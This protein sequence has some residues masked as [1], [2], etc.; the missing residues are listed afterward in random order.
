M[1][2]DR[3]SCSESP[4]P[5]IGPLLSHRATAT[6]PA[7]SQNRS[8]TAWASAG[9]GTTSAS[10]KAAGTAGRAYSLRTSWCSCDSATRGFGHLA[11]RRF[12]ESTTQ[13]FCHQATRGGIHPAI[14]RGSVSNHRAT[15]WLGDWATRG[16]S[17]R[18][19]WRPS[20]SS[21]PAQRRTAKE[22]IVRLNRHRRVRSSR[23]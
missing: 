2:P 3:L 13:G 23:S 1:C 6:G 5:C 12:A 17:H 21:Q 9:R 4:N 20:A 11:I 19:T 22:P 18:A 14:R 10:G 15:W 8:A 16:F 7:D